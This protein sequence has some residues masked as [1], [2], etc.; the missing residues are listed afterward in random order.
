MDGVHVVYWLGY[1]SVA[2]LGSSS[3]KVLLG[4]MLE[5]LKTIEVLHDPP[6]MLL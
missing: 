3:I 1:R 5:T 2:E 6:K 4:E